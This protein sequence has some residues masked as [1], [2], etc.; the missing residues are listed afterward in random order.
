[1]CI[2]H[3]RLL[4]NFQRTTVSNIPYSLELVRAARTEVEIGSALE[5]TVKLSDLNRVEAL[6]SKNK[7]GLDEKW[8]YLLYNLLAPIIPLKDSRYS[9]IWL[10]YVCDILTEGA[11]G[12]R[13]IF[14]LA[15]A[16]RLARNSSRAIDR[17]TKSTGTESSLSLLRYLRRGVHWPANS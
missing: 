3:S 6:H 16:H 17:G 10:K 8:S 9:K 12:G 11:F 13:V 2:C 7:C 1:M 5:E 14:M 15:H 4:T